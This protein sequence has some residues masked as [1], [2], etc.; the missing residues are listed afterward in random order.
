[1]SGNSWLRESFEQEEN[2]AL[3]FFSTT[4]PPSQFTDLIENVKRFVKVHESLRKIALITSGGTIVPLEKNT[5][6]YLDNFSGGG[7]GSAS[8]EYF[9]ASG[10]AVIFL[11]RRH[12]LQP[13][14]RHFL[15]HKQNNFLDYL[16]YNEET[17]SVQVIDEY[18]EQIANVLR[19]HA[20]ANKKGLLLKI[21]FQSIHEYLFLLKGAAQAL[22]ASGSRAL[23]YS[24]AAVSDFYIPFAKMVEHKIQSGSGGLDLHLEPVPKMLGLLSNEWA[25]RAFVV[26]FKLETEEALLATK[27]CKSLRHYGHQLVIGNLLQSHKDQVLLFPKGCEKAKEPS[28]SKI[29][30]RTAKQIE[31]NEDIEKSLVVE[32]IKMHDS[33]ISS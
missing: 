27:A 16:T 30:R 31:T 28:A 15:L 8:A 32:V 18:N 19:L 23:I 9:I 1:M 6:R 7:R 21:A 17:N 25:P 33:F 22:E 26:S 2:K 4:S 29:L 24:A 14:G 20:E 13:Y 5:V 12:S 10:Y 11:Y 3:D